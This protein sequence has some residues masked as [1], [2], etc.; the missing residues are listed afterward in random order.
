MHIADLFRLTWGALRSQ[1][2][3]ASLTIL[4]IAIGIAAV[5][6]LTSIGQGVQRFILD[7]FTQFGTTII[8]RTRGHRT[9]PVR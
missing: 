3:R 7:E 6:L 1:Y 8:G 4:G 5:V 9:N 2:L